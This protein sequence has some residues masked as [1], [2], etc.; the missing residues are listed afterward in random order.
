MHLLFNWLPVKS[1]C[2][3]VPHWVL[4]W[5]ETLKESWVTSAS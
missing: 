2:L 3:A 4:L 5:Q 1:R